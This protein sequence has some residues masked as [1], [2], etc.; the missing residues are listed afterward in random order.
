[1]TRLSAL[2]IVCGLLPGAAG[3]AGQAPATE[4]ATLAGGCFWCLEEALEKIPGV[5]SATSGYTGGTLKDPTYEQVSSG[6]TGHT[7]AV[8][9][10]FD[11]SRVTYSQILDLFWRNIDPLDAAGQ[12]CDRGS[13]YRAGI[14]VH[15]ENQR[16]AAE[17]SS[18]TIIASLRGPVSGAPPT[19]VTE[20]VS[21]GPF[22]V[23][24]EY[25]Q[26]YYKKNPFQYRFYKFSCGR[27]RRLEQVWGKKK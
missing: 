20:I 11:P 8:R 1:M 10:T 7:E 24:E 12:F 5:I 26:D 21:A 9:I 15:D 25:H 6:R 19:I 13:Q 4:E 14:F 27:E 2:L 17:S 22:Y 3:M 16:R 23:A 18:Q